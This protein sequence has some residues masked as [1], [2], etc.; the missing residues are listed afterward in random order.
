MDT[1]IFGDFCHRKRAEIELAFIE[2]VLLV[3]DDGAR[4]L[5]EG[6]FALFDGVDNPLGGTDV[7]L[8][9]LFGFF[10][11]AGVFGEFEVVVANPQTWNIGISQSDGESPPGRRKARR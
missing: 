11:R 8:Q 3:F 1:D 10:G 5:E 6:V 7:V 2:K 4:D 9:E